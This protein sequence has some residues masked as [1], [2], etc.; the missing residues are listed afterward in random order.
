MSYFNPVTT[1]IVLVL[2]GVAGT[3]LASAGGSSKLRGFFL[4]ASAVGLIL[5]LIMMVID[6]CNRITS[7]RR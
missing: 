7:G 6:G 3:M 4:G 2:F 5:L 1:L